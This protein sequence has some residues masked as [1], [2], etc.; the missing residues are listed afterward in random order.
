MEEW[1]SKIPLPI[2]KYIEESNEKELLRVAEMADAHALRQES[3][4]VPRVDRRNCVTYTSADSLRKPSDEPKDNSVVGNQALWVYCKKVEHTISQRRH[5]K[6]QF[7]KKGSYHANPV[8]SNTNSSQGS[9][10]R[11]LLSRVMSHSK[12]DQKFPISILRDTGGA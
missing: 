10:S 1:K 7:S 6:C 9:G 11:P 2:L 8:A 3:W 4:N 5:P 12:D